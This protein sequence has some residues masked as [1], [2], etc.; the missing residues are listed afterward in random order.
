MEVATPRRA[1]TQMRR[2]RAATVE[3][4]FLGKIVDVIWRGSQRTTS[5]MS[6][7]ISFYVL[8]LFTKTEDEYHNEYL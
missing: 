4:R 7:H 3:E 1:S 2:T 5:S 8:T 6:E